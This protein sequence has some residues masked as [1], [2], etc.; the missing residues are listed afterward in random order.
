MRSDADVLAAINVARSYD[1]TVNLEAIFGSNIIYDHLGRVLSAEIMS[2]VSSALTIYRRFPFFH[3][4]QSRTQERPGLTKGK[5]GQTPTANH[6]TS[7]RR[8]C[9]LENVVQ[10]SIVS[11]GDSL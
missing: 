2:Q 11:A 1:G 4:S 10:L 3:H 8:I 9:N 7:F 5:Q 6:C